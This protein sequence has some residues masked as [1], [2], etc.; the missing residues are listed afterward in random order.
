MPTPAEFWDHLLDDPYVGPDGEPRDR[1]P[2]HVLV[3]YGSAN[4]AFAVEQASAARA[5]VAALRT[6][7]PDMIAE[8]IRTALA[9]GVVDVDISVRDRTAND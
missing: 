3:S 8:E 5:E 9:Q 6:A 4:A 1:K 7:L 2:A